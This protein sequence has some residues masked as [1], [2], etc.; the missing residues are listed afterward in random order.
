MSASDL[1][2]LLSNDLCVEHNLIIETIKASSS[3]IELFRNT[4]QDEA[5]YDTLLNALNEQ[6]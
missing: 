1:I 6:F 5:L 4:L 2:N 3:G